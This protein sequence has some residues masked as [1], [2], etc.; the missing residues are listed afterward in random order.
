MANDLFFKHSPSKLR[1]EIEQRASSDPRSLP[2]KA[3]IFAAVANLQGFDQWPELKT[4]AEVDRLIAAQHRELNRGIS[5]T[6]GVPAIFYAKELLTGAMYPGTLAA[7]GTGIHLSTPSAFPTDLAAVPQFPRLSKTARKYAS[8]DDTGAILR[9][10]LNPNA[11]ILANEQIREIRRDNRNRAREAGL[12]DFGALT[13]ALGFDGFLCE[14]LDTAQEESWY[15]IVNRTTL[16]FQNIA[17]LL[18]NKTVT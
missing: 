8:D 10:A 5:G 6:K 3:K 18:V 12:L 1:A 14:K 4:P 2:W 11:K 16:I 7:F 9:C 15:V 13:A 17:L